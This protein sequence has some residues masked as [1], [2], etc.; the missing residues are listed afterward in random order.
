MKPDYIYIKTDSC[1]GFYYPKS[2][3]LLIKE[4][5]KVFDNHAHVEITPV[6]EEEARKII[7]KVTVCKV[8]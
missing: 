7:E 8:V 1:E 2:L 4:P 6:T 5:L 3:L